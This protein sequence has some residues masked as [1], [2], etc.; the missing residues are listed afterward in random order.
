[1]SSDN[2]GLGSGIY[3][4]GEESARAPFIHPDLTPRALGVGRGRKA[5][6][7]LRW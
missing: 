2:E 5:E 1:M 4:S 6:A 3:K 7:L